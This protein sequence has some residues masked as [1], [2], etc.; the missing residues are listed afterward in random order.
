MMPCTPRLALMNPIATKLSVFVHAGSPLSSAMLPPIPPLIPRPN[1]PTPPCP[2]FHDASAAAIVKS[3]WMNVPRTSHLRV[4]L[5]IL[6]PR[7]PMKA[8]RLKVMREVRACW[9]ALWKEASRRE[10]PPGVAEGV[11]SKRRA[12]ARASWAKLPVWKPHQTKMAE[13]EMQSL[14]TYV[15]H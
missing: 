2:L 11:N 7:R 6:S 13:K 10:G 8:P 4:W 5:P 15:C 9:S 12:M 3:A 14:R 1:M